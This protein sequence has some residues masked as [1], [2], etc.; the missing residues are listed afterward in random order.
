MYGSGVGGS[1]SHSA[2]HGQNAIVRQPRLAG[3][4]QRAGRLALVLV[5]PER[6]RD[7]V[8]A[9]EQVDLAREVAALA[10]ESDRGQRPLADDHRMN[11]LDR[12]VTGVGARRRRHAERDQPAAAGEA[13][14]HQMAEPREPLR[15]GGEERAV[16]LGALLEQLIQPRG[17][18]TGQ[19]G[20]HASASS[21]AA[22]AD[23]QSRQ[24]SIPSPVRALTSIRSTSGWT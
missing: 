12:D 7:V 18:A 1:N 19:G 15:L 22:T 21:R 3:D 10:G 20:L 9:R 14:G 8:R 23:S 6:D 17:G 4:G 24:A 13:L 5:G 16:R 2:S 11:E